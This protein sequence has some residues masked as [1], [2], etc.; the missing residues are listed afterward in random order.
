MSA[1]NDQFLNRPGADQM[2]RVL[3][4]I[5]LSTFFDEHYE[6]KF[7]HV[8]RGDPG[9]YH[10]LLT[11]RDID[12]AM[13]T[14]SPRKLQM[15]MADA[16]KEELK[17][18]EY[19][20]AGDF[21]DPI[22]M[23]RLFE[24]GSTII[25]PQLHE[26]IP[27]LAK[28]TRALESYFTL[29]T[30]TNIYVTPGHS[31][32]FKPH[33]DTHDVFILQVQGRKRWRLYESIFELPHRSQPFQLGEHEAGEVTDEFVLEAGDTLYIPRGIMHSAV[34]FDGM[35][36]MHVTTGLMV[37]TWAEFF[38]EAITR[39]A[40]EDP[41]MRENLPAGY[42]YTGRDMERMGAAYQEKLEY[43][44]ERMDFGDVVQHFAQD[45]ASKTR[46]ALHGQFLQME[47]LDKLTI[48]SRCRPRAEAVFHAEA[49]E[50]E[51]TLHCFG[52]E[53][54]FPEFVTPALNFVLSTPSF[55]VRELPDVMD[56]DGKLV[57]VRKLVREGLLVVEKF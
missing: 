45:F 20:F 46:P 21:V 33:W 12:W 42:G 29:R 8:S 57:M 48:D 6:K 35:T 49:S 27:K 37:R 26:R 34:C 15:N 14:L 36:S 50:A 17:S 40:A 3:D 30:Q 11:L 25:L 1:S 51:V 52:N 56:E 7:L 28:L 43:L 47:R 31:Q 24:E 55:Q 2:R 32:G 16:N 23:C 5:A 10:D 18:S 44:L 38:I 4:P 22:K 13:T 54:T 19:T 39:L 53:V 41:R 9:R